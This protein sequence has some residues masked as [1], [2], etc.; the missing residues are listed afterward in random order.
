M[1]TIR[2]PSAVPEGGTWTFSSGIHGVVLGPPKADTVDSSTST[3][4]TDAV[5]G[6]YD[7]ERAVK[8]HP[9]PGEKRRDRE[10]AQIAIGPGHSS[11]SGSLTGFVL[12]PEDFE[13][14]EE[15][16]SAEPEQAETLLIF[17]DSSFGIGQL[18]GLVVDSD[19]RRE[20]ESEP[21]M[22]LEEFLLDHGGKGDAPEVLGGGDPLKGLNVARPRPDPKPPCQPVKSKGQRGHTFECPGFSE[23]TNPSGDD[24]GETGT[25]DRETDAG[26]AAIIPVRITYT[27]K[28]GRVVVDGE[29]EVVSRPPWSAGSTTAAGED[30]DP[31]IESGTAMA[32]AGQPACVCGRFPQPRH[33]QGVRLDDQPLE[34]ISASS[35]VVSFTLPAGIAPGEHVAGGLPAVGFTQDDRWH[36]TALQ[37]RGSLDQ[38]QL[39][40][41]G[42]TSLT[43]D[44]LGTGQS[45][46]IRLRNATPGVVSLEGGDEQVAKSSGGEPNRIER[47]INA[48]GPGGFNIEWALDTETCPC[49]RP[50]GLLARELWICYTSSDVTPKDTPGCFA[51][52]CSDDCTCDDLTALEDTQTCSV[53]PSPYQ[54]MR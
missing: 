51:L 34:L 27:D 24:A 43:L 41:G 2:R 48:R 17:V 38:E 32:F 30:V 46:D 20:A 33:W 39:R 5:I 9:D 40:R 28:Y 12:E 26:D 8:G 25:E 7:V 23:V 1:G 54:A 42:S 29:Q 31:S 36:I 14:L 37:L 3:L 49:S 53:A 16:D 35:R 19:D 50:A 11:A 22:S 18:R 4:L 13:A 6:T 21:P 45:L 47:T 52:K 10:K 44:V 15:L